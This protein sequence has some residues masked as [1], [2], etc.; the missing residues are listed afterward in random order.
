ML[1]STVAR[2]GKTTFMGGQ[3][4][5]FGKVDIDFKSFPHTD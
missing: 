2:E 3:V 4:V 5:A 1:A